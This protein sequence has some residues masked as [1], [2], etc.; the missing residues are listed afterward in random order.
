MKSA[1]F[2]LVLWI[3]IGF[4]A[5]AA[6]RTAATM[7]PVRQ[8]TQ[9]RAKPWMNSQIE[10]TDLIKSILTQGG[11][12]GK[13][14]TLVGYYR[15]WDLLRETNQAPPVTRSDWV[16]KDQG[17]AIYVQSKST[18]IKGQEKLG[19]KELQPADKESVN[20]MVRLIG[21]VRMTQQKQAYIEP[22]S[23]EILK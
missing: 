11:W 2:A 3:G 7:L 6:A 21:T 20:H 15:G 5:M 4:A 13:D 9:T 12:D 1:I 16:I 18:A 19:G 23:L 14:V 22:K 17:G 10:L 8:G